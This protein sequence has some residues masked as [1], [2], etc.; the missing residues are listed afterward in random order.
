MRTTQAGRARRGSRHR[1]AAERLER[2]DMLSVSIERTSL[3]LRF[4]ADVQAPEVAYGEYQTF[5]ITNDGPLALSDV[6]VRATNF[7]PTQKVQLGSGEDG[8]YSLGSLGVGSASA[9]TAFIYM[10][11][12][13]VTKPPAFDPQT[14]TIEV[15]QGVPGTPGSTLVGSQ[16]D[17]FQW[18]GEAND[19]D[20]SARTDTVAV[21]YDY[22]GSPTT[23]PV[24][25]GTMTMTVTG[26]IKNKP[27]RILFSPASTLAWPADAFVLE[28]A[29]VTYSVGPQLPPDVIF[30]KPIASKPKDF[31]VVYTFRV[32][33][34]TA[35]AT[36]VTPVQYTANGVQDLQS[37]KFDHSP[38]PDGLPPIPPATLPAVA[39]LQIEKRDF[40]QAYTPGLPLQW[41][42]TVTNNGP[43][44]VIG[45][46]VQDL[47]PPQ[48]SGTTWTAVFTGG[49]GTTSG[50]GN[51][52]ELV[53]LGI[54]GTAVYTVNASTFST[55][56]GSLTNTA[57]VTAPAGTIDPNL[58]NNTWTDVD[59]WSPIA[60]LAITKV[61]GSPTYV[62][63]EATT[64]T[65]T[66]TNNGP[67]FATGAS[68]V[69]TFSAAFTSVSWTAAF[70]G[71]GSSGTTSG[72]GSIAETINLAAGGTATYTIQA[73]VAA[74]A[75]TAITNTATVTPP[76]STSD[77]N[78][79]NNT[80]ADTN[81]AT[82][83][84]SLSIGKTD[85]VTT[86]VPGLATT[87][88]VTV[89]NEGPSFLND[90]W[91]VD[92]L[93]AA[94]SG[95]TWTAT[96]TGSGS[97]GPASGS[98]NLGPST[99]TFDLAVGGTATFTI[100]APVV[101]TATGPLVNTAT[102][103]VPAGTTNTNPVTSATDTDAPAPSADLRATKTDGTSQYVPDTTTTYTIV[104]S[105][106]GVSAVTVARVTDTFPSQIDPLS[107]WI[108][109]FTNGS[110]TTSGSG[111]ISELVNLGVG[112][113][114][115]YT[116]TARILPDATGN[117]VNTVT[118]A[119]PDGTT[120]PNP[121]NNTAT[122]IDTIDPSVDLVV[123]K[124]DET[125]TYTPGTTQTYTVTVTNASS[126]GVTGARVQDSLPP[127][128][129]PPAS[130]GRPSSPAAAAP[131]AGRATSTNSSIST[132]AASWSTRSRP[133]RSRPPPARCRT[134]RP[135]RRR[136]ASPTRIP[137][138]TPR[139]TSMRHCPSPISPSR[140]TIPP[141]PT[142][143]ARR[144]P[145]PWW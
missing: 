93:P 100:N 82:P 128:S 77:P 97:S 10:V 101:S 126:V 29:V 145:T 20:S 140:R 31:T 12:T 127:R 139:R 117:L 83:R 80:A 36:P 75:T 61:D 91:L 49:S 32:A 120:D 4:S 104:V 99:A 123:V 56:T 33:G 42:I 74:T 3:N 132:P 54:G 72:T 48:V 103:N 34:T 57:T 41:R 92:L 114:V 7:S 68:V 95:A 9:E 11:A 109:V 137:T 15:W 67:S 51:I 5:R 142:C 124:I 35:S 64:Y 70:T 58:S 105:N 129:I 45:A 65:V 138:T 30:E 71:T 122:D 37:R 38:V 60:D 16:N 107:T 144:R 13:E 136:R 26:D 131:P 28:D 88:V 24:V 39:D 85:G 112:G 79:A 130:V 116:V 23:R 19:D 111:S 94:V 96:Y 102:I 73:T 141:P 66:V 86:Y 59:L 17:L 47:F 121:L 25:G 50:S 133:P 1:L 69:D 81:T 43:S 89:R 63:G 22:E 84:V 113:F 52:N 119:P 98:G 8:L 115:V 118:V 90:G 106:G 76:P 87:Y 2:R 110:G 53:N 78:L 14:Y 108:A 44:P 135:S 18:V 27:D 134:R 55:A 62:P 6:W 21:T 40:V 46:R 125:T 143:R